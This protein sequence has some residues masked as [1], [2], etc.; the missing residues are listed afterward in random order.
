[1][2]NNIEKA[3]KR[4]SAF[5]EFKIFMTEYIQVIMGKKKDLIISL[6]FPVLAAFIVIWIA[7]ENMFV[8]Y[9]GT[10]SGSFVIVS[11]AIW[12]GLFNSIQTIVKDR[13]NVKR[14]YITGS[15]MRCYTASRAFVQLILCAIQSAILSL[16]YVGVALVYGNDLPE[17]GI[18]T[19]FPI[20]EFY[21]SILLLMYAADTMGIMISCLVKKEE[22]ANVLAPYILIVQLIFSGILFAMEGMADYISYIMISRW[23]ME[24]LGSIANLNDLKLKIQMTVPTVPHEFEKG[25]EATSEH[26]LMVWAVLLGFIV[27]FLLLG[28]ILLHRV[29]KDTKG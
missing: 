19:D 26:L 11:A 29:S 8:H 10:K 5:K 16:S 9:D 7:G 28:N 3:P 6:M 4:I 18:L 23:G 12:G 20:L 21:I 1:M 24:A 13:K 14:Y 15:R 27:V 17:K 25:F 2:S 22:A